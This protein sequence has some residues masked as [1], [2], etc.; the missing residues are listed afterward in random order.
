MTCAPALGRI[1]GGWP[2]VV[3]RSAE[4][5]DQLQSGFERK[6]HSKPLTRERTRPDNQLPL[7]APPSVPDPIIDE[8]RAIDLDHTTPLDALRHLQSLQ[9]R[10]NK[11]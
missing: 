10:L 5:L 3:T 9:D 11:S 6:G 8:I 2:R 4:I 1:S 7:F